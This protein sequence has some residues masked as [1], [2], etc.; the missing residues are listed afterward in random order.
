ML[1]DKTITCH[2]YS[3]D[4]VNKFYHHIDNLDRFYPRAALKDCVYV[5]ST[6]LV[7]IDMK[8][9]LSKRNRHTNNSGGVCTQ[10]YRRRRK[11]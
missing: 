7:C 5:T 10:K 6:S 3:N 2:F 4:H 9:S 1:V 11:E 8:S